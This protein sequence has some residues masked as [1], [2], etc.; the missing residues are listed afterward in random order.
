MAASCSRIFICLNSFITGFW[1]VSVVHKFNCATFL[2]D[3]FA[4][5]EPILWVCLTVSWQNLNIL[6]VS[7]SLSWQTW[8]YWACAL[9]YLN[10]LE[11]I[12]SVPYFILTNLN[13]LWVWLI[14]SWQTWIY[15]ECSLHYINKLE[16]IVSVL[17]IILT[18]SNIL[19]VCPTVSCKTWLYCECDL[20]YP[21][22]LEFILN[23]LSIIDDASDQTGRSHIS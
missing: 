2:S 21:E 9:H 4:I 5:Y 19:W 23:F 18:N 11:Y 17:Y 6:W 15:C 16:Y 10:K 22:K 8:I 12:V 1:F 3:L 7:L 20:Q 14:L 13:I